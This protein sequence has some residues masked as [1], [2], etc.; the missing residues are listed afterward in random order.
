[1]AVPAGAVGHLADGAPPAPPVVDLRHLG[2]DARSAAGRGRCPRGAGLASVGGLHHRPGAPARRDRCEAAVGAVVAHR[3]L[4]RM[5]RIRRSGGTNRAITASAGPAG[6]LTLKTHALVDGQGRALVLIVSPGQANDSPILPKLLDELRVPPLWSGPATD[7]PGLPAWRQGVLRTR[8]PIA[9]ALARHHSR[10]PRTRGS[11]RPPQA[12]RLPRRPAGQLRRP[13]LQ[14]LQ[15]RRAVLRPHEE[16]TRPGQPLRQARPRLP[17][18][19]RPRR[20]PG[21]APITSETRP[22]RRGRGPGLR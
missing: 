1:M 12:Q 20:D 16:L 9:A 13:G 15:R 21:L 2:S 18:R 17:R 8:P 10:D 7:H 11:D 22:R 3:G 14:A 19:R 6:G 5:T 4:V